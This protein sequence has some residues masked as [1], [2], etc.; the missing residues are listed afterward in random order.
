MLKAIRDKERLTVLASIERTQAGKLLLEVLEEEL[1]EIK[2]RLIDCADGSYE[3]VRG[4]GKAVRELL[5]L[6]RGAEV[7]AEKRK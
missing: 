4:R 7:A 6:L 3:Q 1:D 2:N 5:D